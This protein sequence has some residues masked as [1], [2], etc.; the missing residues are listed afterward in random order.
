M[1]SHCA[2]NILSTYIPKTKNYL[3]KLPIFEPLILEEKRKKKITCR[4]FG[5]LMVIED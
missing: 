3:T 5:I 1:I 4:G 2:P